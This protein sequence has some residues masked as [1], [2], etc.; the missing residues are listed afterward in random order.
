ME[1]ARPEAEWIA[2]ALS[3]SGRDKHQRPWVLSTE[4]RSVHT[5][6]QLRPV[7]PGKATQESVSG[8]LWNGPELYPCFCPPPPKDLAT[9]L[10]GHRVA[11]L[12][13]DAEAELLLLVGDVAG[14]C[15]DQ[16]HGQ[17]AGHTRDGARLGRHS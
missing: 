15:A 14:D 12:T 9:W 6:V 11:A 4:I 17:G 3:H 7:H 2:Q 1:Q 10:G 8:R 13:L 16:G 5:L